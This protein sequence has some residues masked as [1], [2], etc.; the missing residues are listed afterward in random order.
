MLNWNE[1][2]KVNVIKKKKVHS[3]GLQTLSSL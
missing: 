3:V 1:N 2:V